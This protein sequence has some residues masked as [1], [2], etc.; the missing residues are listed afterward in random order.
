MT[1]EEKI[2]TYDIHINTIEEHEIVETDACQ[3]HFFNYNG[4]RCSY[5]SRG[6]IVQLLN[7]RNTDDKYVLV[8]VDKQS[9]GWIKES[10]ERVISDFR[11]KCVNSILDTIKL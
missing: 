1:T 5:N 7:Y 2:Y 10:Y 6:A 8:S 9:L 3:F 11:F 4:S